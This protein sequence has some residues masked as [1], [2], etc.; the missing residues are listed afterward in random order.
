MDADDSIVFGSQDRGW[1]KI[2]NSFQKI[3][4]TKTRT[5]TLAVAVLSKFTV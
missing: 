4:Y 2:T 1:P 5:S 3:S